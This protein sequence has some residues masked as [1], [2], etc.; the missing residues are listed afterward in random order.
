MNKAEA[1]KWLEN[2]G[3]LGTNFP[4]NIVMEIMVEYAQQVSIGFVRFL[5]DG[6]PMLVGE[7]A[8]HDIDIDTTA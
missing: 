2:R 7:K 6:K 1:E 8:D 5:M 3:Y 4:I